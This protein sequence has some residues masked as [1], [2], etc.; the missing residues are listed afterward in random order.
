[1][2]ITFTI[3]C[4]VRSVDGAVDRP[5]KRRG[6][7]DASSA[8]SS[9]CRSGARRP[10]SEWPRRRLRSRWT[11]RRPPSPPGGGAGITSA[12]FGTVANPDSPSD[13]MD[14]EL[15][16]LTN[17]AG[18]EVKIMTYGGVIQSIQ[19]PDRDRRDGERDARLRQPRP[20]REPEP[21]LRRHH[22]DGTPTASPTVSSP[23]TMRPINW[24]STMTRTACTA[25]TSGS[26]SGCGRPRR[27]TTATTSVCGSPTPA[28]TARRTIP[29]R[30]MSR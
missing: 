29:A 24:R 26:T 6:G 19:V 1:M 5:I 25:G 3:E 18:M 15:Y 7:P 21:L 16:T 27:S 20:V 12:P 28:P 30:S 8:S 10:W 11:P 23:S 4:D 13:G 14:V 9:R 22:R 17:A 2:M